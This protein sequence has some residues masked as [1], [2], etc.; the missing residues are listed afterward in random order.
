MAVSRLFQPLALRSLELK[1]RALI[2]PMCMYSAGPD[3]VPNDWHLMHL[4]A[5][6]TGGFSLVLT[7]AT[8]VAPEGRIS[9][10]DL[11][12]WSDEQIP[13]F[14]RIAD[15]VHEH[16]EGAKVGV[17][18][19]HA[20]RKASTTPGLPGFSGG[21]LTEQ[22]GAWRTLGPTSE[23]FGDLPAPAAM[24]EEQILRTVRDFAD[25]ARRAVAAGMDTVQIHAAHGYLL[26]EF[27]Q[28]AVNTRE[29]RWGG[30]LE[31]RMRFPLAVVE[32][33][34]AE[35]PAA[36]PLLLRVSAADW[37]GDTAEET[38]RNNDADLADVAAFVARARDLGVDL[39]DV[40]SGGNEPHPRV[41]PGPGY[42]TAFAQRIRQETGLATSAV[43]IL[44]DPVQ[45]EHVL[46][47]DQADA[48]SIGREALREP[49]WALRA[50]RELGAETAWPGQYARARR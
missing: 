2:A 49:R 46:V 17:Q 9:P 22:E 21:A 39:V 12:L 32:A 28:A 29:D 13:G 36:T 44:T 7:E 43:G 20:G 3:G 25:A 15:F 23:P 4:G 40:S 37:R 35:L 30:S 14:A 38:T 1:N 34:R 27:L 33:V 31:N 19:A 26:H 24:T 10:R 45:A 48:V 42:Q 18:L 47:S 50:A 16:G 8:A 41:Q 11:G 5:F 6:A